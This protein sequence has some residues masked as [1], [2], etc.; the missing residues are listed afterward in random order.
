MNLEENK[1]PTILGIFLLVGLFSGLIALQKTGVLRSR[2]GKKIRPQEVKQTNI[3]SGSFVVSWI[4]PE[5]ATG[6]VKVKP[7]GQ[8]QVFI[9]VRDNLGNPQKRTTHYVE[10]KGLE[11]NQIYEYVLVS[12]GNE[13]SKD[14]QAYKQKTAGLIGQE[15]PQ[16]N[17]ASGKVITQEGNPAQGA[18]VYLDIEGISP[19]SSIVSTKG[20]WAVSLAKAYSQDLQ[21][22]ADY[23]EGE[24]LEK[25]FVQAAER[26]TSTGQTYTQ[27]DD[28]V[29]TITLGED[30]DFTAQADQQKDQDLSKQPTLPPSSSGRFSDDSINFSQQE[31]FK[32][33]SPQDG[34]TVNVSKPEIF[35]TGPQGGEVKITLESSTTYEASLDIGTDQQWKWAPPQELEPGSH[36]LTV[37][38]TDPETGE[39]EEYQRTFVLA[40]ETDGSPAFSATPSGDTVTPTSSPSP[41]LTSTPTPEPTATI[42]PT[43]TSTSSAR[44]SQPSTESGVPESGFWQITGGLIMGGAIIFLLLGWQII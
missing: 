14:N 42:S 7:D 28:P 44:T 33:I 15:L 19:L 2:A 40:A 35:G 18:I 10:V 32:I 37:S 6:M 27:Q 25:I 20:N 41:T 22:L 8:E 31:E 36:T 9:D 16:A 34:E 13:F 21:T 3:T 39:V 5:A 17:L 11:H 24:V 38:Y 29:A 23:Q 26:G 30:F 4:T 12:N 1:I 43:A